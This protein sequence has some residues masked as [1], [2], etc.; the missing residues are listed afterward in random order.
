MK[1]N[2]QML[3]HYRWVFRVWGEG[4]GAIKRSRIRGQGELVKHG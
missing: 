1:A 2:D 3:I 4:R